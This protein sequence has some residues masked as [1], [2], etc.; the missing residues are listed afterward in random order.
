LLDSCSIF[1]IVNPTNMN[2][3]CGQCGKQ[4]GKYAKPWYACSGCG[5]FL[6][7]SCSPARRTVH[8]CIKCWRLAY[9][10]EQKQRAETPVECKSCHK[11]YLPAEMANPYVPTLCKGCD[12]IVSEAKRFEAAEKK[13]KNARHG[14]VEVISGIHQP[15]Q[16]GG[17]GYSYHCSGLKLELGDIVLL[18]PSWVDTEIHGKY[19]PIEGT[20]V[21]TYSDYD[22]PV[23]SIIRLV[24]KAG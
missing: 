19:D 18:P 23:K 1:A 7:L 14:L 15:Q 8:Q 3:L 12:E 2:E 22:G 20:V 16:D 11:K 13:R 17:S 10:A 21:S 5:V 9:E 24:K 6:C 4:R